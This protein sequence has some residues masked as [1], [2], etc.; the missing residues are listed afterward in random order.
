MD[1]ESKNDFRFGA[2]PPSA[3]L[4]SAYVPMQEGVEPHYLPQ[5]AIARGTLFPGLDLPFRGMVNQ[6]L[7]ATPLGEPDESV[8]AASPTTPAALTSVGLPSLSGASVTP[9]AP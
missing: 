4:G 5:T 3:P 8:T 9:F 7:P 1:K 6:P 2:L